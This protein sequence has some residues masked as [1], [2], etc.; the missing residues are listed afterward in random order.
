MARRWLLTVLTGTA[1]S[2]GFAGTASAQELVTEPVVV[3]AEL[4]EVA[5]TADTS[6][7][8]FEAEVSTDATVEE[9]D[10]DVSPEVTAGVSPDGPSLDVDG[11][12]EVAG[13][14]VPVTEVTEP[15]EDAVA[16][17]GTG[18]SA[19]GS[20]VTPA[21]GPAPVTAAPA[22]A[23]PAPA[24][25]PSSS[26]F[27]HSRPLSADGATARRGMW[28]ETST[29][30]YDDSGILA[31]EVAPPADALPIVAAA[32]PT[33]A[34]DLSLPIIDTTPTVPALLRLLA[35]LLVVGAAATWQTVRNELA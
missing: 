34:T 33:I 14:E 2:F 27:S 26:S 35:G 20:D 9:A 1:L 7:R 17:P 28:A 4:V 24:A 29:Y 10:T 5:A 22:T 25:E 12:T 32:A 13:T 21:P 16:Q 18:Q 15:V 11:T 31:P 19:A 30:A 6:E 8:T 3:D 23:G